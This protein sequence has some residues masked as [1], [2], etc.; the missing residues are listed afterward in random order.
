MS[1]AESALEKIVTAIEREAV[2]DYRELLAE[3]LRSRILQMPDEAKA[4][5]N[6]CRESVENFKA[7]PREDEG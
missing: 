4:G 5:W 6:A 1:D 7:P 2:E 3:F